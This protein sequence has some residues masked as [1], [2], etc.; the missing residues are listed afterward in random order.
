MAPSVSEPLITSFW[1]DA[2]VTAATAALQGQLD[3]PTPSS[4]LISCQDGSAPQVVDAKWECPPPPMVLQA[5]QS[6]TPA[7]QRAHLIEALRNETNLRFELWQWVQ[8]PPAG[9]P[10]PASPP[11]GR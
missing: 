1:A 6:G 3:H 8:A 11:P 4:R 5:L 9:S 7:E 2:K 10:V